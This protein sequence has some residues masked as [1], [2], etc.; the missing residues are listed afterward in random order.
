MPIRGDLSL[1]VSPFI[2]CKKISPTHTGQ[3]TWQSHGWS[4]KK[5]VLPAR[6]RA[7]AEIGGPFAASRDTI[8]QRALSGG[9]PGHGYR[10]KGRRAR[11]G[12]PVVAV[13]G[14]GAD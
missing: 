12:P 10:P 2:P 14:R 9:D 5:A 6:S 4:K 7:A 13:A 3:I 11:T 1:T 8:T